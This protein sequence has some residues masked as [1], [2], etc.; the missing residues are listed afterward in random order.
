M[1]TK[2]RKS[3][4]RQAVLNYSN[5]HLRWIKTFQQSFFSLF[6]STSHV[7]YCSFNYSLKLKLLPFTHPHVTPNFLSSVEVEHQRRFIT[8]IFL[9]IHK[10]NVCIGVQCCFEHW[11]LL[12]YRNKHF[13]RLSSFVVKVLPDMRISQ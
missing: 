4:K 9:Y 13:F 3:T 1:E 8:I 5:Q 10:M 11:W 2:K 7:D 6:W 12:L